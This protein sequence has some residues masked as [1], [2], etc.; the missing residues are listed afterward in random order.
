MSEMDMDRRPRMRSYMQ[1]KDLDTEGC[2]RL[3]A[4]VL[5]EAGQALTVAAQQAAAHPTADNMRHLK[6]CRDFYQSEM[7]QALSLGA[8]D[9]TTAAKKIIQNAL[10]GRAV[11]G[12]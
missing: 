1:P 5:S 11:K 4:A 8:V 6:D 2:I 9:G 10:R 3:A 12:V 7:F